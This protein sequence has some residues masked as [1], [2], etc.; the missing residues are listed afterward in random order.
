MHSYQGKQSGTQCLRWAA[1]L[2][3]VG[4]FCG[5]SAEDGP[6]LGRVSGTVTLDGEPV[7]NVIVNFEPSSGGRA[8]FAI[9]DDNGR[10]QLRFTSKRKGALPG[11]HHVR[12][13]PNGIEVETVIP[14]EEWTYKVPQHYSG[15]HFLVHEVTT[16]RNTI[17]FQLQ[18]DPALADVTT[19]DS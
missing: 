17:D 7:P 18:K 6:E 13:A 2:L 9:T 8:S 4:S 11:K 10:Y 1:L 15:K 5:C 12:I 16:G 14:A 3:M 19:L